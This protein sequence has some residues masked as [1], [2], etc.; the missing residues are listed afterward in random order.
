MFG[1]MLLLMKMMMIMII[2]VV[3]RININ[4]MDIGS[5]HSSVGSR[6]DE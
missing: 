4:A 2:K 1:L 3:P 6:M 5:M